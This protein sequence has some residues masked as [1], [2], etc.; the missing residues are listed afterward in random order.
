LAS[1]YLPIPSVLTTLTQ[2]QTFSVA[3]H[4]NTVSEKVVVYKSAC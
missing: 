4:A 3:S 2:P 1:T